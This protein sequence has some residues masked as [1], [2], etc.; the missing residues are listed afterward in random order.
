MG[1]TSAATRGPAPRAALNEVIPAASAKCAR[2]AHE[3]APETGSTGLPFGP[4]D[5]PLGLCRAISRRDRRR[6]VFRDLTR[7]PPSL[8][9]DAIDGGSGDPRHR[10][11]AGSICS[12]CAH[13]PSATTA[14][15][16]RATGKAD[17]IL[18]GCARGARP[19]V[20]H[21]AARLLARRAAVFGR[22]V[23]GQIGRACWM[24]AAATGSTVFGAP[25]PPSP[26][27]GARSSRRKI[28]GHDRGCL[29][30]PSLCLKPVFR[31]CW[32]PL[33]WISVPLT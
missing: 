26:G 16:H 1:M 10:H 21:V 15:P 32:P 30:R 14:S 29:S 11:G 28:A 20:Q 4:C 7:A 9:G 22:S 27:T 31:P 3:N 25:S 13:P 17:G 33:M 18:P 24:Q 12:F 2:A 23:G 19:S 5:Q 6:R 8:H